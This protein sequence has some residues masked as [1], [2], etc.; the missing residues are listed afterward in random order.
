MGTDTLV[1][2][3]APRPGTGR[4]QGVARGS[5]DPPHKNTQPAQTG[6]E[7]AFDFAPYAILKPI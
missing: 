7:A 6:S 1:R 3:P 2:S 5:G 4:D